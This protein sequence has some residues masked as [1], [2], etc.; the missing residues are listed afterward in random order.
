M[1]ITNKR[2]I[3][4]ETIYIIKWKRLGGRIRQGKAI[5]D[6]QRAGWPG[7]SSFKCE[8]YSSMPG[9]SY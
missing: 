6:W 7:S 9:D 3:E 8:L 4:E 2:L 5:S 1:R